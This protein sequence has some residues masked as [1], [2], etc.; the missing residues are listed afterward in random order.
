MAA[1]ATEF[2]APHPL[3]RLGPAAVVTVVLALAA[4]VEVR[5]AHARRAQREDAAHVR[6][7]AARAVG[8]ELALH[9]AS[10]WLRHPTRS[11]PWAASA[12]APAMLDL[13]PAGALAPPPS[14]ALRSG[15]P[16]VRLSVR[17]R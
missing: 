2:A 8:P 17:R 16:A 1:M 13:D 4:I 7:A 9:S 3:A 10:R 14:A 12:D 5:D 6:S 11:E 15:W